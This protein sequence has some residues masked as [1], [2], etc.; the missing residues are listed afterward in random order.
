MM[1]AMTNVRQEKEIPATRRRKNDKCI[2][3]AT[4]QSTTTDL[5]TEN[6][7]N[8]FGD[9]SRKSINQTIDNTTVTCQINEDIKH[10]TQTKY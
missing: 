2:F 1:L 7:S 5:V 8:L 4:H 10:H 3:A 6:D 9:H